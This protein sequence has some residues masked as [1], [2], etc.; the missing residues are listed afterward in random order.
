MGRV[1][2]EV[3]ADIPMAEAGGHARMGGGQ[4]S[5]AHMRGLGPSDGLSQDQLR[6]RVLD[7]VAANT[8]DR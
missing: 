7:A 8:G 4:L 3:V 1:L 2:D 6:D 5:V